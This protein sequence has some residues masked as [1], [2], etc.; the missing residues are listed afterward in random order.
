MTALDV[1][2]PTFTP[3]IEMGRFLVNNKDLFSNCIKMLFSNRSAAGKI[4]ALEREL[5]KQAEAKLASG[6]SKESATAVSN[7]ME[8]QG[9][10]DFVSNEINKVSQTADTSILKKFF[11]NTLEG[12][13]NTSISGVLGIGK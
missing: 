10:F 7:L 8:E 11:E 5:T 6:F 3:I 9:C 12:L 4:E 1:A 13:I 2:F